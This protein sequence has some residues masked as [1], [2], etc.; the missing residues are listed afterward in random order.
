MYDSLV[1]QQ[2]KVST[3]YN[4]II[5]LLSLLFPARCPVRGSVCGCGEGWLP[6]GR[7]R[8]ARPGLARPAPRGTAGGG[9]QAITIVVSP[10]VYK[11]DHSRTL[12]S[13]I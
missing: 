11:T 10:R 1:K 9:I 8:S 7:C 3:T 5:S 4:V 12:A 13:T 6:T 2:N